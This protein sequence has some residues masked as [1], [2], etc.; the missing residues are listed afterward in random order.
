MLPNRM[1]RD[2]LD[3]EVPSPS[4]NSR[5]DSLRVENGARY[6]MYM[7]YAALYTL[8]GQVFRHISDLFL[9]RESPITIFR[10]GNRTELSGIV[11]ILT[12]LQT[13]YQ[14]PNWDSAYHDVAAY[15]R[16]TDEEDA[17]LRA[18]YLESSSS[19]R[20]W[21]PEEEAIFNRQRQQY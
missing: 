21:D 13:I 10:L 3:E 17:R 19:G 6:W 16:H 20:R 5:P 2:L 4:P 7:A 15:C 11:R 8:K 9:G 1:D 14:A 12:I 18:L